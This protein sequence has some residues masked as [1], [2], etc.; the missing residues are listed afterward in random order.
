MALLLFRL[1]SDKRHK[2]MSRAILLSAAILA[3]ISIFIV[4]LRCS[5]SQPWIFIN[6]QCTNL[7]ILLLWLIILMLTKAKLIRWKV[8]L[9][10]DIITELALVGNSVY[11]VQD[12]HVPLGK[13]I[14]VVLAFALRL[15]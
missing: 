5:L 13:K 3:V 1:S 4:A 10:F 6:E 9:A 8:V 2:W 14:V 7:V 12:L 11:L 15:P